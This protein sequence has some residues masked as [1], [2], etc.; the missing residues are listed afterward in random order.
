MLAPI[1]SE[2]IFKATGIKSY[3]ELLNS[4]GV[5]DNDDDMQIID[6]LDLNYLMLV[7]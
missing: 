1:K 4:A 5:L 3:V 2:E 6:E 7:R